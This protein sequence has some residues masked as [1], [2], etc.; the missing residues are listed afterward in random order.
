MLHRASLLGCEIDRFSMNDAVEA[1]ER[2]VASGQP[3]QYV[4]INASKVIAL[5]KDERLREIV[6]H[7]GLVTADGQSVVWASRLLGDPLPE[8]VAGIDL[9]ERLLET[10]EE[11]GWR[12]F[13]LG[14]R[15]ETLAVALERLHERY[16]LLWIRGRNGWFDDSESDVVAARIRLARPD[17]LLVA[18]TSPRKEY[19]AAEH[20]AEL[21]VPLIVGV[22]GAIDVIAGERRRAPA[23]LQ[24]AGLEWLFRLAQEPVRLGRRYLVTNTGFILVVARELLGK[25]R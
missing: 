3:T 4:A 19:W 24:R 12:V 1:C 15:E 13:V 21:G 6:A 22:G 14:A 5:R 8:R 7:A 9:M 20:A 23:V 18:M 16:P 11:R 17:V 10:A 2:I 25:A